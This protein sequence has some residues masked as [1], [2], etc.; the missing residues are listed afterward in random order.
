MSRRS[1]RTS[2]A[3]LCA[4][5]LCAVF[6][7]GA[8][9]ASAGSLRPH[10]TAKQK[11]AIHKNL[12]RQLRQ[13]HGKAIRSAR[14]LRL[15]AITDYQLPLT[16][17]L[18]PKVAANTFAPSNDAAAIDLGSTFGTVTPKLYGSIRAKGRFA[19]PFEGGTLGEIDVTVPST[20]NAVGTAL[21]TDPINLL[22][23]ADV[24]GAPVASNGC[25]DF[26]FS[27]DPPDNPAAWADVPG[28]TVFRTTALSLSVNSGGGVANLLSD[29]ASD[30][31]ARL[32]LNLGARIWS[33]FR[34][35]DNAS[36]LNCRQAVTGYVDNS[37]PSKVIGTLKISPSTTFDGYLR[38]AKIA[39]HGIPTSINV[40][41][42]L[43]PD[44][45]YAA[46]PGLGTSAAAF[47]AFP[48]NTHHD[49]N[50]SGAGVQFLPNDA[51]TVALNGNLNVTSLTGDVLV[52]YTNNAD[53]QSGNG[54][55]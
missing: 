53:E 27:T 8:T 47:P 29:G 15:A 44:S 18:N 40:A 35:L 23:N 19:D 9:S 52:G 50:F 22:S 25:S 28:T 7:V 32:A 41:A 12:N 6:T 42:C 16:I 33:V 14:W 1:A 38:L 45:V 30:Q 20:D 3:A 43:S 54:T 39:V 48:C 46:T 17:R 37:L 5:A 21:R 34:T 4:V 13:S 55:H 26:D 49:A 24:T 36:P 2:I 10:Y 31:G 11:A 51:A